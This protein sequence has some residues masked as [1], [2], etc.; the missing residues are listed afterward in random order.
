MNFS[1]TQQDPKRKYV[2]IG[3]VVLLHVGVVYALMTGLAR[4]VV[5]V[6]QAPLETK[7]IEELKKLPPPP[8]PKP[9]L[10]EPVAQPQPQQAPPPAYVPPV[11]V[12]VQ[13]PANPAPS[14]TVSNQA[15]PP[16]APKAA[17]APAKDPVLVAP[18]INA[19]QNCRKPVYPSISRREEEE[20]VVVLR[21][22]VA[23]DGN[24]IDSQVKSSSG[25]TRL[26]EAAR[27]A[28]SL[29]K[30]QPGT[31]DGTPTQAWAQMKYEWRLE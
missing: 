14:I 13:A 1:K 17:P 24:V 8:P 19:A 9:K 2:G 20:G 5:E 29:C 21:F 22:L 28:L 23:A 6:V 26:D 7:I 25:Y 31:A 12:A 4:K 10:P 15:P 16:E 3:I 30:F 18:V 27:Q 11:Q